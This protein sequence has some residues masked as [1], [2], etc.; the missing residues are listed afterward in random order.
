M[1]LRLRLAEKAKQLEIKIALDE[2]RRRGEGAGL[3]EEDV[4]R[5]IE[6]QRLSERGRCKE[7]Q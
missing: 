7:R 6:F 4:L 2:M 5:E 1:G 3:T